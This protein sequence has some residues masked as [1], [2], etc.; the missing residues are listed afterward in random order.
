MRLLLKNGA[1]VAQ[2]NKFGEAPLY[3]AAENGSVS[4]FARGLG[5]R[6]G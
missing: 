5:R 3:V 1:D 4:R 6:R 2:A